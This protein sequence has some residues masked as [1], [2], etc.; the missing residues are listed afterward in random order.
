MK[1]ISEWTEWFLSKSYGIVTYLFISSLT[2][3]FGGWDWLDRWVYMSSALL[4]ILLIEQ[5]RRS[6]TAMHAKLDVI[7][8]DRVQNKLEKL[9]EE[10]IEKV[11][12]K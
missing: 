6:D 11:R 3:A 2:Y 12:N 9:S 1:Y 4:V 8:G 5:G 10:E 7:S